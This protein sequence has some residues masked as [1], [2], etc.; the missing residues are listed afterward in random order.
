MALV[1]VVTFIFIFIFINIVKKLGTTFRPTSNLDNDY[2]KLAL[3]FVGWFFTS[4]IYQNIF[5]TLEKDFRSYEKILFVIASSIATSKLIVISLEVFIL[6]AKDQFESNLNNNIEALGKSFKKI[7]KITFSSLI[8]ILT[9][10]IAFNFETISFLIFIVYLYKLNKE[11]INLS[12]VND[13]ILN[14]LFNNIP[15]SLYKSLTGPFKI[16][17]LIVFLISAVFYRLVF[18][19]S[20]FEITKKLTAKINRQQVERISTKSTKVTDIPESYREEF[21]SL[22]L[23]E[24]RQKWLKEKEKSISTSIPR[25][26]EN[27]SSISFSHLVG[28]PGSGRSI[29]IEDIK[30][31]FADLKPVTIKINEKITSSDQFKQFMSSEK[32]KL[33]NESR[34]IIIDNAENLYLNSPGNF[35]ALKELFNIERSNQD[36]YYFINIF[37][38]Y[39]WLH[40][41]DFFGQINSNEIFTLGG[42]SDKEL[43]QLILDKNKKAKIKITFDKAIYEATNKKGLRNQQDNVST[44]Y[45]RMIWE[46]TNGTPLMA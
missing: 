37:D 40:I 27:S 19:L 31:K 9:L 32:E 4:S 14:Y 21:S 12:E 20:Y 34:L 16:V 46:Q 41:K 22:K 18:T 33:N 23:D 5:I 30:S 3:T 17:S 28:D 11:L 15:H 2:I 39:P 44:Y 8:L 24:Y 10:N 1:P 25:W 35:E 13:S 6:N 45:F 38:Y 26:V 43:S 36:N 42:F 7:K 29:L